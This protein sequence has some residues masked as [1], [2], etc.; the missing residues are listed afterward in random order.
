VTKKELGNIHRE[1]RSK[2]NM[3]YPETDVLSTR[4]I[5]EK[6]H[7]LFDAWC[8]ALYNKE[9]TCEQLRQELVDFENT[10]WVKKV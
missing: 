10:K 9:K 4:E 1:K 2:N 8:T 7:A 3:N 5:V 6:Q